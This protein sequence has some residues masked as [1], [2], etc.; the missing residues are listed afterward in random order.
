TAINAGR[1]YGILDRAIGRH[2]H[3]VL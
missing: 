2:R 1:F 3:A